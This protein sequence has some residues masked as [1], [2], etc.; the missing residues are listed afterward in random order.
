MPHSR[1]TK[2]GLLAKVNFPLYTVQ[3]LSNRHV[4]VGGGG[5]SSKTGVAN[6]F[7]VYELS[8]DGEMFLADEVLRYETGPNVVMNC[9]TFSDNKHSYLVAGQESHCQLFNVQSVLVNNNINIENL[10]SHN[11][12][13]NRKNK[14]TQI[15]DNSIKNNV[16]L[17]FR[18]VPSDSV[19]TDFLHDEPIQRV[20][21]ISRFSRI[22]A[23]GG[24]DGFIRLWHFPG[25]KQLHTLK[26]HKQE[27]DDLDF[28]PC[29]SYLIS[30]AKDGLAILWDYNNGKELKRLTWQ[31]PNG[32]K[33]LYK[34]CR[35]GIIEGEEKSSSLYMLSNPTGCARKQKSFL[36]KWL[37][38]EG[39]LVKAVALD[40]SLS[41]LAVRDDGRFVALGTMFSGS[42]SIYVAFSLQRVL[43]VPGAH[44][45]FVTGLEFL[46]VSSDPKTVNS[47]AEAAVLSISVDNQVCIHSLPFRSTLPA[48]LAI[49]V[50]IATLLFTFMNKNMIDLKLV[51]CVSLISY[52]SSFIEQLVYKND[53]PKCCN[54]DEV[55]TSVRSLQNKAF[56]CVYDD[57]RTSHILVNSSTSTVNK[58]SCIDD[59]VDDSSNRRIA[60][61]NRETYVVE[62]VHINIFPKCCPISSVYN[63]VDHSCIPI[64][65]YTNYTTL[66]EDIL[67]PYLNKA[68]LYLTIAM[69]QCQRVIVDYE[70]PSFQ[71]ILYE[72]DGNVSLETQQNFILRYLLH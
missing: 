56:Q 32:S 9:S 14:P 42:V 60:I 7:E 12:I 47:I 11:D 63:L 44:S 55:L 6:G 48:W 50:I 22:M 46:P 52:S 3:M 71:D 67:K 51:F 16:K 1:R 13:R 66:T 8:H 27:I 58:V 28:S 20:V 2:D 40:E 62:N 33:Y 30:V 10:D 69:S 61:V 29:Q 21:R 23:T 35:F 53:I 26:G 5:G 59:F 49:I 37:P 57:Y 31:Q 43:H 64:N 25:F 45:M 54:E 72:K 36:Q 24:T 65:N 34:R 15:S 39:T 19:Q 4:L 68:I 70:V 41:A 38:T 18:I 17:K